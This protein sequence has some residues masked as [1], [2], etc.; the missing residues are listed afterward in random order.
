[1][2]HPMQRNLL[3]G[4][5]LRR[6][7]SCWWEV[8]GLQAGGAVWIGTVY[9]LVEKTLDDR[10]SVLHCLPKSSACLL[11]GNTGSRGLEEENL[12]TSWVQ[13]VEATSDLLP[14]LCPQE[15]DRAAPV[16]LP[17]RRRWTEAR[18]LWLGLTKVGM[19]W[20][21][22][23]LPYPHYPSPRAKHITQHLFL[24]VLCSCFSVFTSFL[25]LPFLF[26]SSGPQMNHSQLLRS[27]YPFV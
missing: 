4:W 6:R 25:L 7:K 15:W 2:G 18:L 19:N 5:R 26:P 23:S 21:L 22:S 24:W 12:G 20:W 27:L 3:Q 9:C 13:S 1:M 14:L 11:C 16:L 10:N 17:S 8:Q